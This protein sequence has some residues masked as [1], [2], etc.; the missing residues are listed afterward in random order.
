V[1]PPMPVPEISVGMGDMDLIDLTMPDLPSLEIAPPPD[2][3]DLDHFTKVQRRRVRHR[4]VVRSATPPPRATRPVL[5]GSRRVLVFVGGLVLLFLLGSAL[6]TAVGA[7][8]FGGVF[9]L[10]GLLGL[11]VVLWIGLVLA[12]T[13]RR[14]ATA[15]GAAYERLEVLGRALREVVPGAVQELPV[16]LPAQM[17]V[18]DLPVAYSELRYLAG[19][20]DERSMDLAVNLL[21]GAIASL[22]G[23]DDVVLA[24]RTFPVH[25]RGLLTQS[26]REEISQPVITRRRVYVGPGE[27]EERITQTLRTDRPMSVQ[28][29]VHSLVGPDGRGQVRRLL[30]WVDRALAENPPDLEALASPDEA[31]AELERYR[32]ALRQADPELY[33]LLEDEIRRGL[34]AVMPRSVPSSLLD[35]ARYG[36][37]ASRLRQSQRR[38]GS[39][40][41]RKR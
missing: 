21:T 26:A 23:R 11:A 25:T 13:G 27:L 41:R 6:M 3:P 34:G 36:S 35:L 31:L 24:R 33:K 9:C 30:T 20:G 22:V 8:S 1:P 32:E 14:V 12:R 2:I 37:A 15:T 4:P 28:E 19:Q 17:G 18:L 7:A 38:S 39:T 5:P 40:R 16:N 29:L 10:A